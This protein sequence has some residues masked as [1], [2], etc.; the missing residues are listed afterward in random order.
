MS[1]LKSITLHVPEAVWRKI[2]RL[3]IKEET[4]IINIAAEALLAY[5]KWLYKAEMQD[6]EAAEL[7]RTQQELA[8]IDA[9]LEELLKERKLAKR[10]RGRHKKKEKPAKYVPDPSAIINQQPQNLP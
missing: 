3:A 8:A 10:R 2:Q 7:A 1:D 9:E 5:A 4:T 6:R